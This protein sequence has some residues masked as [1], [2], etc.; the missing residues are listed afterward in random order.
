[1]EEEK[2]LLE[3]RLQRLEQELSQSQASS[4]IRS[5]AGTAEELLSMEGKMK[6]TM[7]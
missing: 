7:E 6:E 1:M 2:S 3:G 4:N 5:S